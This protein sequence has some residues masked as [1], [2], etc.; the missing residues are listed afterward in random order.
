M[1]RGV[2]QADLA[3]VTFDQILDMKEHMI[4]KTAKV[5]QEIDDKKVSRILQEFIVQDEKHVK[6][7]RDIVDKL[8][9]S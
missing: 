4:K 7:I 2:S 3:K 9:L 6:M 1:T 8:H 5:M